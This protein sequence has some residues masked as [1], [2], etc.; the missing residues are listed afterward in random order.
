MVGS[1]AVAPQNFQ[2]EQIKNNIIDTHDVWKAM[3]YGARFPS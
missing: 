3:R 2:H 1:I